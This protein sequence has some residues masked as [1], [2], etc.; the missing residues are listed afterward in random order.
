MQVECSSQSSFLS[1]RENFAAETSKI[2]WYSRTNA[3]LGVLFEWWGFASLFY[4][5][6]PK[7]V[8]QVCKELTASPIK[9]LDANLCGSATLEYRRLHPASCASRFS[10]PACCVGS[11]NRDAE[12]PRRRQVPREMS[13][14]THKILERL[15]LA[16]PASSPAAW[17]SAAQYEQQRDIDRLNR[18]AQA[19]AQT[20]AQPG[21]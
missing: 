15:G 6:T 11:R 7:F 21:L 2:N 4:N 3:Y 12:S 20:S 9:L 1:A 19:D 16:S 18:W 14:L 10:R 17:S 13:K 8:A 5:F